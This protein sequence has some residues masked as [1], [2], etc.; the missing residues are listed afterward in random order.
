MIKKY[1]LPHFKIKTFLVFFLNFLI[2]NSAVFANDDKKIYNK[3]NFF[4]KPA[5]SIEYNAPGVSGA[6]NNKRFATTEHIL[7]QLYN[8]ENIAIGAH[9]RFHDNFGLNANWVQTSLDSTA[10]KNAEPLAKKAVYKID[11][12]NFSVLGYAPVIKNFFELFGE[13]GLSDMR[14]NLSYTDINGKSVNRNSHQ[15]RFF[16]SAGLQLSLN[17][18]NTFRFSAQRYVGK[19][20][21]IDSDYTTIRIGFLRFF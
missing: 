12:Y 16:Y 18:I 10:L 21:L 9:I 20:G 14:G 1:F 15:T 13:L 11:H 8:L 17:D 7:K 2:I 3:N 4:L 19:V 5:I 6:G